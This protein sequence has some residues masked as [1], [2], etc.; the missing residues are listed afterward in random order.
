M[1]ERDILL[2]Y[3]MAYK[4]A[5]DPECCKDGAPDKLSIKA[6]LKRGMKKGLAKT[7]QVMDRGINAVNNTV[8]E[9]VKG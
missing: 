8:K 6:R 9:A 3:V 2:N 7:K 1:N 5:N 4:S